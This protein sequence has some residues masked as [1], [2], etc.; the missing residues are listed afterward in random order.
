VS[1]AIP[2]VLTTGETVKA[3]SKPT[4]RSNVNKGKKAH[5][6]VVSLPDGTATIKRSFGEYGKA[7]EAGCY[8]RRG[9]WHVAGIWPTTSTP[10]HYTVVPV[11][12][13]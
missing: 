2:D 13:L 5:T 12:L 11:T 7:A 1:S 9:K 3:R 6:Y 10:S 4:P 8:L